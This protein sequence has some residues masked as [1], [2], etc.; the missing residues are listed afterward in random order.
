MT[1]EEASA[2]YGGDFAAIQAAVLE[3][4]RGRWFLGEFARR[5]RIAE[6]DVLLQAIR[7]LEH[8]APGTEGAAQA[9]PAGSHFASAADALTRAKANLAEIGAAK[10]ASSDILRATERLQELAWELRETGASPEVCDE[11]DRA[12]A[13]ICTACAFQELM[14]ERIGAAIEALRVVDN[15]L[16]TLANGTAAPVDDAKSLAETEEL[17]APCSAPTATAIEPSSPELL[18]DGGSSTAEPVGPSLAPEAPSPVNPR[19][20]E[21]AEP[22]TVSLDKLLAIDRLDFRERVRL[23]T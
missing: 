5:N 17:A 23:F 14:A 6:T 8:S 22:R 19:Y 3:T 9:N 15:G 21:P 18:P 16:T 10:T 1:D 7:R 13:R 12:A 2:A 20:P 4:P 11:L